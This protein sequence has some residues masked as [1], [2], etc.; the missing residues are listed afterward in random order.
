MTL[1]EK[2]RNNAKNNLKT[3]VL[4]EGEEIRIIKAAEFLNNEKLVTPVL[5]GSEQQIQK[6]AIENN[7]SVNGI[8][9]IDPQNSS[10]IK[11]FTNEY[12]E[13]RKSKG[14]TRDLASETLKNSLY[15]G[16]FM[17]R[18]NQAAGAVAGSINTTGDV[19]RAAIQVVG[20]APGIKAVSSCFIIVMP[21]GREYTFGDCAVI[22]NPDAEQLASIAISSSLT[23]KR[24]VGE[25]PM[26][27]MLSFSTKWTIFLN[28]K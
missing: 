24:L 21:D 11:S 20:V 5:I 25:E 15:Y 8:E 10:E 4:P 19:L 1:I 17:V 26:V 22:P 6:I 18:N 23:H 16:A 27:A 3:I 2:I 12:F 28:V 9:I 13:L 7:C 14:M